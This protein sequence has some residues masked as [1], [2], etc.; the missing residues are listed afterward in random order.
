PRNVNGESGRPG[1]GN[2]QAP[3]FEAAGSRPPD[4]ARE[5]VAGVVV[6]LDRNRPRMPVEIPQSVGEVGVPRL[7]LRRPGVVVRL[8]VDVPPAERGVLAPQAERDLV[9]AQAAG[10]E[11]RVVG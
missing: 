8:P 2:G 5:A 3:V 9:V 10:G 4:A 7:L 11:V 6:V 1:A